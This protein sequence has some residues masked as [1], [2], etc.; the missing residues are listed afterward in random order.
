MLPLMCS[1]PSCRA[2][3]A[4]V[5]STRGAFTQGV[6]GRTA[7]RS[8]MPG[9]TR[10]DRTRHPGTTP[11]TRPMGGCTAL[12]CCVG[13]ERASVGLQLLQ[14][15]DG[16]TLLDNFE[17][18]TAIGAAGEIQLTPPTMDASRD[19]STLTMKLPRRHRRYNANRPRASFWNCRYQCSYRWEH[20][21]SH[22]RGGAPR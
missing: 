7:I 17:R 15:A 4:P 9:Q 10:P 1:A 13:G 22:A 2:S 21:R 18:Y 3:L 12:G 19:A 6:L 8:R 16:T 14:R 5:R 11:C 20:A